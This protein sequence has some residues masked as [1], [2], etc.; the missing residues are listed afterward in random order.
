MENKKKNPSK[1]S[2]DLNYT[3][4]NDI[5]QRLPGE[6]STYDCRRESNE[7][8]DRSRR[9]SQIL[10]ILN[11]CYPLPL[12]ARNITKTMLNLGHIPIFDM[13]YVKP[14]LTELMYVGR[15]EQYGTTKDTFTNR[16]VTLFRLIKDTEVLNE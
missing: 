6:V 12:T 16:T 5:C 11:G 9:Y 3:I 2:Y 1:S 14:R 7:T 15:V 4:N 13:N 8:V 10:E